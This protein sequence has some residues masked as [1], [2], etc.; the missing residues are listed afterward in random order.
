MAREKNSRVLYEVDLAAKGY[1]E[2]VV[3]VDKDTGCKDTFILQRFGN[4]R[5]TARF[6]ASPAQA[7]KIAS[8]KGKLRITVGMVRNFHS[9]GWGR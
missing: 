2:R 4:P 5:A 6:R 8:G 9:C 1:L 3:R 7:R